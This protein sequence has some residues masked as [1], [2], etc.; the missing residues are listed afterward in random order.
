M[1]KWQ[2]LKTEL[3]KLAKVIFDSS[4]E[5]VQLESHRESDLKARLISG[6]KDMELEYLPERDVVRWETPDEYGFER[7]PEN[8]GQL[9]RQLIGWVRK[10]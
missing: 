8:P 7:I 1:E 2:A 3:R 6:T 10:R 5:V 4:Q 9:A